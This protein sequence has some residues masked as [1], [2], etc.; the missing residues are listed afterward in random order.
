MIKTSA[1]AKFTTPQKHALDSSRNLG[2]RANAGSGKTSV[3]VDRIIQILEQNRPA[4]ENEFTPGPTPVFSIE[5]IV[6]ITFTKK[7]AGELKA[8]LMKLLQ[9]LEVQ[10][11]GH[12]K[13]WWAQQIEK[14]EDAPIGTIDSF[15]GSILRENAL[16][17]DSEDRIEPDFELMDPYDAQELQGIAVQLVLESQGEMHPQLAEALAWWKNLDGAEV[18]EGNLLKLLGN[19]AGVKA[20]L[21]G[22]PQVNPEAEAIKR[23]NTD[24]AYVKLQK[25]K[26]ELLQMLNALQT[27]GGQERK[28]TATLEGLISNSVEAQQMLEGDVAG[29][30]IASINFLAE[31]L[32]TQKG[33]PL[34]FKGC[35][36]VRDE[37]NALHESWALPLAAKR[38]DFELEKQALLARNY[39][40]LILA[41]VDQKYKALCLQKN[42]YDFDT[43]ARGVLRLFER[44]PTII[45]DLK[46]RY[47]FIQVDEFQDTSRLQWEILSYLVGNGPDP[48]QPLDA[49]RLFIVGD[50]QQSIY[51]FRQADVSVFSEVIKKI[52]IGNQANN[53]HQVQTLHERHSTEIASPEVR[54]GDVKLSENFRTLAISPLGVFNHLFN[55]VFD[56]VTHSIDSSKSYEVKFQELVTGLDKESKGEVVYIDYQAKENDDEADGMSMG[57]VRM[58]VE[59]LIR[60]KSAPRSKLGEDNLPKVFS[61]K[62]MA[63]LVPSRNDTL[64][65]LEE[66]LRSLGIPYL[67]HGGVGFWQR[68]EVLDMMQLCQSLSQPGNDLALLGV[69]RGP[70]LRCNDADLYFFHCLGS[71]RMPRGLSILNSIDVNLEQAC[72]GKLKHLKT[73]DRKD[74]NEA[75]V[76]FSDE[77]RTRLVRASKSIGLLG[78]WRLL[79]DRVS[80]ADLLQ[81]CMEQTG[82][83]AIYASLPD[84]EQVLANL[85]KF[86][87]FLRNEESKPGSSLAKVAHA[88]EERVEASNRDSQANPGSHGIDAVQIMTI[89]ASKGLQFPL[90]VVANM[91]KTVSRNKTES[92]LA[93]NEGE[94]GLKIRHPLNPRKIVADSKFDLIKKDIDS[95][96]LAE[97]RRLFYVGTTRAEE[98]LVLAGHKP[99]RDIQSWRSWIYKALGLEPSH[100]ERGYW[101]KDAMRIRCRLRSDAGQLKNETQDKGEETKEDLRR[102]SETPRIVTLSVT[103]I[104]DEIK[105]FEEKPAEWKLRNTH[106]VLN[107]Y[108]L[109]RFDTEPEDDIRKYIGALIGNTVHR[110]LE[111]HG[112][113]LDS[114]KDEQLVWIHKMVDV[115]IGLALAE[116]GEEQASV[117]SADE[118]QKIKAQVVKL[119][120]TAKGSEIKPLV[121]AEGK[122][123]IE[124]LLPIAGYVIQGRIDKLLN[125]G[126]VVEI[127]DWKT[128]AGSAKKSIDHHQFQM[129]LYALAL[130]N[131]NLIPQEQDF[132]RAR[133]VLLEHDALHTYEFSKQDLKKFEKELAGK[134]QKM[135]QKLLEE[136]D[137][138]ELQVL[139]HAM[140]DQR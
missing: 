78:D 36:A 105:M 92:I 33:G 121:I 13:K 138:E 101:E 112:E 63:I 115:E 137:R 34:K 12:V 11:G 71:G 21:K 18:L 53:L 25:E 48:D 109:P 47:R 91:Q 75:W 28:K 74:L 103:R 130:L 107:F 62:D 66:H 26:N 134:M 80:H 84:G 3:L 65:K 1:N 127:I 98:V 64:R 55:Y 129:K 128:D 135:N 39:L 69:L 122:V 67:L 61:W 89:H 7:A 20:V 45:A 58:I 54:M 6:S 93:S 29:K 10:S 119:L 49:D 41:E 85:G 35:D 102:F 19:S 32:L 60:F 136:V 111:R 96:E 99:S 38:I 86:F 90:V 77:D 22:N 108:S 15:F 70:C 120:E 116:L 57:Q 82:A 2:V 30:E 110:S 37:I 72:K 76:G 117:L 9:E 40:M 43:V 139:F 73:E 83:Y 68:Q 42:A 123:E 125:Q 8:R 79:V 31:M 51:G 16:L 27:R 114:T 124:F 52:T 23:V 17:D 95:R 94:I 59:E 87:E 14:L 81:H 131:C 5:N 133:L 44:S 46:K 88:L 113:W 97:S 106:H 140:P 24:P 118:I 104:E 4:D 132:V 100:F 50:P 126:G 56:P